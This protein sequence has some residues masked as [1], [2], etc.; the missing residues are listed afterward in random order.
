MQPIKHHPLH[1]KKRIQSP[2]Q[3]IENNLTNNILCFHPR[4]CVKIHLNVLFNHLD[5]FI[6]HR[7][8]FSH[9]FFIIPI[10]TKFLQQSVQCLY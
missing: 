2:S 8:L 4:V 1:D 6:H 5:L 9:R 10:A 3:L 7:I